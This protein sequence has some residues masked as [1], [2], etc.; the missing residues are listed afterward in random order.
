MAAMA[1]MMQSHMG[2]PQDGR[3]GMGNY[4]MGDN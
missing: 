3:P 4:M 1:A 2:G